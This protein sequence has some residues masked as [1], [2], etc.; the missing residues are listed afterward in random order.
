MSMPSRAMQMG[1]IVLACLGSGCAFVDQKVALNYKQAVADA[2]SDRGGSV[3]VEMPVCQEFKQSKEGLY[4]V[5]NVK[6]TW[7]MKT[8]DTV[9]DKSVPQWIADA[10]CAELKAA[11][12]APEVVDRLPTTQNPGVRTRV[13]KVWVEQDPGFWTVGAI[14]E[15]QLRMAV[16]RGDTI[17]KEF[18]VESKGQGPR[19]L[20]GDAV[21]KEDSLRVAL[22]TCMKKA[23]PIVVETFKE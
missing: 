4:I 2:H 20:F 7:G 9:T 17:V 13:I 18:D 23:V 3:K 8:A 15:V 10:L 1:M 6:N 14:G 12:F 11:G 5:G 21:T 16:C 19:G 22:E